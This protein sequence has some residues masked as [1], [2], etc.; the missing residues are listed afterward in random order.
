[1]LQRQ[2]CWMPLMQAAGVKCLQQEVAQLGWFTA[3]WLRA[4]CT[5]GYILLSLCEYSQ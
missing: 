1:M 2:P 3:C 5:A 4:W